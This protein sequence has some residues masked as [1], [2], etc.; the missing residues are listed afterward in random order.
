MTIIY[1]PISAEINISTANTITTATNVGQGCLVRVFNTSGSANVLHFQY[2]NATEYANMTIA[3]SESII[4]WKNNTDLIASN[5]NMLAVQ[6][7]YKSL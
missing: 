7:C 4:V 1:K 3:N 2:A 6:V 5:G